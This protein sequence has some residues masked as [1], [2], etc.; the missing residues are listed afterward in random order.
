MRRRQERR[1]KQNEKSSGGQGFDKISLHP[2]NEK[3]Q[4]YLQAIDDYPIVIATG[5]PG[6][7][8]SLLAIYKAVEY[9]D[10]RKIEKIYLIKP[11]AKVAGETDLGSLPG[12]LEEKVCPYLQSLKDS[13]LVFMSP[14]R[15][16][17]ILEKKIIE[18]LPLAYLRGR[19]LSRAFVIG[20]E[21]QNLTSHSA[22]TLLSRIG[23]DTKVVLN[24][25]VAQRDLKASFGK[26]GLTDV[27]D[28]LRHT[29]LVH[30]VEFGF[31]HIERSE[32]AK[33]VILAY[34]DLYSK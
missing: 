1:S 30:H 9:L 17:Y 26:D 31:E 34:R 5:C 15:A 19:T 4:E 18:F 6:T 20:D 22:F 23:E 12:T 13:L 29:E 32:I 21:M 33:Q 11:T 28:R 16:D 24:G 3:Q 10:K 27:V 14:G 25:D 8:K 2:R 7:A